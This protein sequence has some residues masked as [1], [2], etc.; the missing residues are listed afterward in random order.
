MKYLFGLWILLQ[1][2]GC[3]TF[4]NKDKEKAVL[5][6]EMA[7]TQIENGNLPL[8]LKDLLTAE[9][10]DPKNSAV[11]HSLGLVYFLRERY[12]LSIRHFERAVSISP[13][14]T[15]AR[16]NYARALI[17]MRKYP[18]AEAQLKI[19]VNDLTYTSQE[20]GFLNY[21]ILKFEQKQY[22][23]AAKHFESA[24]RVTPDDCEANNFL[25][26]SL[27]ET[28]S[29][30]RAAEALDRAVGFCQKQ[31]VDEPHYYAALAYYRMG[32]REKAITRFE[33]LIKYYPNGEYREKAKGLIELI[34]KGH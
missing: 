29:Y 11:Q 21:G 30:D 28:K 5:Y 17:E 6:W 14:F 25:G 15:E 31:M 20:K 18:E 7:N 16:N 3:A 19:V 22:R 26:R 34:R 12:D 2:T 4:Q 33:E 27:F 23:E 9:K 10:L 32:N 24:L 8:A 13:D 1:L